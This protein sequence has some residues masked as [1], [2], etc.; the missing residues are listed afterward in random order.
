[1]RPKKAKQMQREMSKGRTTYEQE[2]KYDWLSPLLDAYHVAD[3]EVAVERVKHEKAGGRKVACHEGCHAC[4]LNS[5]VPLNQFE[6]MGLSFYASE[7][8]EA[9]VREIVRTQLINHEETTACPFLVSG[10]C[11]VYPMRPIA[12]RVFHVFDKSCEKGE[13]PIETRPNDIAPFFRK[14]DGAWLSAKRL[15]PLFGI[16][17]ES[18]QRK[19]FESG[20]LFENTRPMHALDWSY[21]VQVMD[22]YDNTI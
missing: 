22:A 19:A 14:G 20:F 1:M 4:C 21:V 13:D 6:L 8:M 12:C 3:A 16:N 11:S 7:V 15:L 9:E 10:R 17:G 5:T 2:L 18:A